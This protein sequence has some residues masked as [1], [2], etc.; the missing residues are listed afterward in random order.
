MFLV[1]KIKGKYGNTITHELLILSHRN[2]GPLTSA[3]DIAGTC[4]Y[5]EYH[6][7]CYSIDWELVVFQDRDMLRVCPTARDER[8]AA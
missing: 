2:T 5:M 3:A 6:E 4:W 8:N 7:F 1:A